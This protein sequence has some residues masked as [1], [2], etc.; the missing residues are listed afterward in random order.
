MAIACVISPAWRTWAKSRTRRRMRFATRGVPR[1][2]RAISLAAARVDADA[3]QPRRALDDALDVGGVV[4]VEPVRD[5]E[6][7]AQRR[8]Q[9][10]GAGRGADQRER[11]QLEPERVGAGPLADH[12][13][14]A[15]VLHRRIEQLLDRAVQAVDLV[16]EEDV[17]RLERGQDRGHV[18]LAVD[19]RARHDPKRRGHLDRDDARERRLAEARRAREEHV[20]A[21]LTAAP[22]GLEEDP[23]CSLTCAWPTN[24]ARLRGRSDR[25]NSSS[26]GATRASGRR[27]SGVALMPH[28]SATRRARAGR[29]P[30]RG[31]VLV[32]VA[33]CGLGLGHRHA[34]PDERV[35]RRG[36]VVAGRRRP[37]RRRSRPRR[38]CP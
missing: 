16:D 4:V 5:A 32:D 17:L 33:Q 18:G 7:V 15:A 9:K 24:S 29:A 8:G 22:G 34:Q 21:R 31:S 3:E 13:V 38:P 6:A 19:G 23:S 10:P 27:S 2:R 12:D 36:M 37:P 14:D 20:L 1:D 30:R 28:P 25:S 35:A 26:P 11:L